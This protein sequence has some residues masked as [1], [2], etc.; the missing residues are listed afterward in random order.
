MTRALL[1]AALL[2]LAACKSLPPPTPP[3]PTPEPVDPPPA[4]EP[5]PAATSCERACANALRLR[6]TS[7]SAL[8]VETCERYADLG[9][10]SAWDSVCMQRATTCAAFEACR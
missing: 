4:P 5:D 7:D 8:C 3:G 1:T 9:G 2:A 10:S 6:C